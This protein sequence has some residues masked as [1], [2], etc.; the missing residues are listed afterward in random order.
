MLKD[1]RYAARI[2]L[3]SKWWT[4]MVVLSLA[5]GI[6]ANTAL[7]SAVNGLAFRTVPVEDPG[8]LIRFRHVGRNQMSQNTSEYGAVNREGDI[9]LGTTFSYPMFREL[10]TANQT[11]VDL[12]AGAPNSQVNVVVDGSAEIATSY[13]AAGNYHG[14]LGIQAVLG[15]TLMPDDDQPTAEPV[16]VVSHGF[17]TRRFGRNPKV[18]GQVVRAN[19]T[20]VTIVGVLSPEFTGIQRAVGVAPDISFPLSLDARINSQAVPPKGTPRLDDPT[21]WWLQVVGRLKPGVSP[22]Q[23]EGNLAGVF[24]QAARAGYDSVLASLTPGERESSQYQDR[25]EV[26]RLQIG[27]GARGLYDVSEAEMRGVTILVVVVAL[28][29]LIVCANVA[30]LQLARAAAR[31]REISVRLSLGATRWRLVRQL[32]TESVVLAFAGA[33]GGWVVAYWGRQ[34]I[35]GLGGQ[36]P[37]D[38]RVLGFAAA[39]ALVSGIL[40]GIAPALR[41]TRFQIGEALKETNRTVAGSRS[42]LGKSLL[43]VQVAVSLMLLIGAGLFLRTVENL[44]RVDVGFNPNNLVLF[45]VNPQLNG[46]DSPRIGALYDQINER[47]QA[48]PGVRAVTM[49]NPP[50][51]SGSVNGTSFIVQ[52]RPFSRGRQND[53]NRVRI[54][55]NFFGTMEIPLLAG[56]DFTPQDNLKAPRVAIINQAAARKF[57]PDENPLGR[58]FGS[59]PENSGEIE[60]VGIVRDAR[61][62]SVR[63][64]AP[65]TMYVPYIQGPLGGMA[66]EVRTAGD[67]AGTLGA[68]REAVRQVDSNVPLMNVSTQLEQIEMRFAQERLL[69]RAYLL[70][71]G[72]AL[73]VAS[74]GLFGLMSYSV[75]RRTNEIGVR[76]A[77]GAERRDVVRMIMGESQRLV[78]IGLAIG[79]AAA[80]A[81]GRLVGTLLFGLQPTD[82]STIALAVVVLAAVSAFAGYV[83]ARRAAGVDPMTALRYE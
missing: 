78:V 56:R 39:V 12:T 41:S 74:I 52:G 19:N 53:I 30:N 29:L 68:I 38:W 60:V 81:A 62:N 32:L 72:L 6:G 16:A 45:R 46:Y 26:S 70:F 8:S 66:Y 4:A 49:S 51:L 5:L 67:P 63:D 11:M 21:Y 33:A 44:R 73:L 3:R 27:S 20:P 28:I 7:F 80:L 77:L 43:V 76:M 55:A 23:V 71:G 10:R 75:A 65:P 61:Y 69:A 64:E 83:P 2:L 17:W 35:P 50:L 25:T 24:Q 36:A 14:L 18:I 15:R 40:F 58:R 34:L 59:S 22:Q 13:I 37:L 9:P 57:F 48:V 1:I 82:S 79:L 31:Q 42:L 47:L 54:A